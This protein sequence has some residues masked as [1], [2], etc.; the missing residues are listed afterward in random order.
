MNLDYLTCRIIEGFWAVQT[1][2][3]SLIG[4]DSHVNFEFVGS[5]KRFRT[6]LARKWSDVRVAPT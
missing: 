3:S 1:A 6:N 5:E 2:V 4:V